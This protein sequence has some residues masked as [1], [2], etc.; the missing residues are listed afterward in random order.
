MI[1]SDC[2][3]TSS[4]EGT[5]MWNFIPWAFFLW[6]SLSATVYS[7]KLSISDVVI[8]LF[9]GSAL[10]HIIWSLLIHNQHIAMAAPLHVSIHNN[11]KWGKLVV[12]GRL[13]AHDTYG[14]PWE[15]QGLAYLT[16]CVSFILIRSLSGMISVWTRRTA[17][18]SAPRGPAPVPP[19]PCCYFSPFYHG[20]S[21][22]LPH[23]ALTCPPTEKR[24]KRTG[25]Y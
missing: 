18:T 2:L 10:V 4:T 1:L 22:L 13:V 19:P 21:S 8:T 24:S 7:K 20:F 6:I 16:T 5:C 11:I 12:F 14:H 25:N 17:L 15:E 9:L 23:R 3:T